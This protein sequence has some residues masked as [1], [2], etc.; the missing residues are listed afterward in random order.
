[1]IDKTITASEAL[2]GFV[3]WLTCR[4]KMPA[5]AMPVNRIAFWCEANNLIVLWCE[6]NNLPPPRQGVYPDNITQPRLLAHRQDEE[7][8]DLNPHPLI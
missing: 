3:A 1:M 2:Y 5:A 4:Q 8:S 7:V 6:T